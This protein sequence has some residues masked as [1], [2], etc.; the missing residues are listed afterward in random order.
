M[1]C[2]FV[3]TVFGLRCGGIPFCWLPVGCAGHGK[4]CALWTDGPWE[5]GVGERRMGSA[6]VAGGDRKLRERS[7]GR[8]P[9]GMV[10]Q[11]GRGE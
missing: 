1:A 2:G 6:A 10:C 7:C 3:F 8:I 11:C 9:A 5:L 4:N